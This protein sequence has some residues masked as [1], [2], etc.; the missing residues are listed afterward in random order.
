[1]HVDVA[2]KADDSTLGGEGQR[3]VLQ[4]SSS[5]KATG[6]R[7]NRSE[8]AKSVRLAIVNSSEQVR[9]ATAYRLRRDEFVC[10]N[11]EQH[12][13][14]C[15]DEKNNAAPCHQVDP[16]ESNSETSLPRRATSGH[17][18]RRS[19]LATNETRIKHG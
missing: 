12:E 3:V 2:R 17:G 19:F 10:E 15:R 9:T 8:S 5:S 7:L 1:M 16:F 11:A 18:N 13:H 6:P 14:D 4:D